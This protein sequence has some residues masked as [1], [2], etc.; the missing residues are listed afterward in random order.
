[1]QH[2]ADRRD[3]VGLGIGGLA[4]VRNAPA[5]PRNRRQRQ[6]AGHH[7]GNEGKNQFHVSSLSITKSPGN[8]PR[9]LRHRKLLAA[10]RSNGGGTGR[11]GFRIQVGAARI[12]HGAILR[13]LV[14]QRDT[15]RDIQAGNIIIGDIV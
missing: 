11:S 10:L 9:G 2:L 1:M 5:Q 3:L 15:G 8:T 4:V 14:Y 12:D 6:P 7:A 13:D